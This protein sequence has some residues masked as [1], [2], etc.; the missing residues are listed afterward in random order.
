[1]QNL[2]EDRHKR[3][4]DLLKERKRV[5]VLDLSKELNTSMVTIRKDLKILEGKKLLHRNHGGASL[6]SPYVNDRSIQEKG[7]INAAEKNAIGSKAAQMIN[8]DQYIIL[9]SGTTVLAMAEYINPLNK[10]TVVTSSLNV[11]VNLTRRENVE[12]L[13]L[14]GYVRE[15]SYSVIGH[16]CDIILKETACS[17]LFLGVDGIDLNYGLTTTNGLEAHLNKQM[18]ESAKEVIVLADSTKFGK[19][20]FGLICG[21]EQV[22][23][24]ITDKHIDPEIVKQINNYGIDLI[25]CN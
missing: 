11:A 14:G 25:I 21:L 23:R 1:M 18:I 20:S 7:F 15:T 10:L 2:M 13:Q 9:A 5:K 8:E 19:K 4:L 3:I 6:D 17:K 24:I 12:V 16:Y 22:D